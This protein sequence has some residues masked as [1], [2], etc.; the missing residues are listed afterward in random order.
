MIWLVLVAVVA[1]AVAAWVL[2]QM[3]YGQYGPERKL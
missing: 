1:C 3:A 2:G